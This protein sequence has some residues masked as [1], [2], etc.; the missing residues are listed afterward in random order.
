MVHN[1]FGELE[2][3][4]SAVTRNALSGTGK[5]LGKLR[6]IT[7]TG[8]HQHRALLQNFAAFMI[9]PNLQTLQGAD[10][11]AD[12]DRS[13]QSRTFDWRMRSLTSNLESIEMA[14]SCVSAIGSDLQTLLFYTPK[15]RIF[16]LEY[17]PKWMGIGYH[18]NAD[19]L[20][21]ALE[22]R[23]RG[24]IQELSVTID[25]VSRLTSSLRSL[26]AFTHLEHLELDVRLFYG[27]YITKEFSQMALAE[28]W[29]F[30]KAVDWGANRLPNLFDVLPESIKSVR[31]IVGYWG[32]DAKALQ[33]LFN[34]TEEDRSRMPLLETIIVHRGTGKIGDSKVYE[35]LHD[36]SEWKAV[37]ELIGEKGFVYEEFEDVRASWLEG[38][39]FDRP[40]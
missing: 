25:S 15:L 29:A 28:Y 8:E 14:Q 9:L 38:S 31:L 20:F 39:S 26:K 40:S 24:T 19:A 16:R 36:P 5:P 2:A 23:C 17:Q 21:R 13:P 37:G 32:S 12:D 1:N 10:Y 11:L 27:P 4:L 33:S 35:E 18:W 34:L 22:T 7:S 3:S 6:S 30:A